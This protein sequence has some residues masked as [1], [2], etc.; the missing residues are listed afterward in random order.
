MAWLIGIDEAGYGPNL[1]PLV[2]SSVAWQVPDTLVAANLW[3]VLNKAVRRQRDADAG[4]VVVDDSK[5][6]Y[7]SSTGLDALETSIAAAV[8]PWMLQPVTLADY[9]ER[10]C[11]ASR[12]GLSGESWYHG[13]TALPVSTPAD[14]PA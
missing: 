13:K 14:L 7:G 9:V 11:P 2:M 4:Q 10:L 1:G 3:Q 5:E 12:P 8:A 6:V